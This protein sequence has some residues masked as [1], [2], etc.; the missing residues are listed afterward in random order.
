M[1][2]AMKSNG[3]F[4]VLNQEIFLFFF[5]QVDLQMKTGR[6]DWLEIE[7]TNG[8]PNFETLT[9]SPT[10]N[11]NTTKNTFSA[12]FHSWHWSK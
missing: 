3:I 10:T 8:E 6:S 11:A 7:Q 1:G 5:G 9:A 12:K 4:I 2:N